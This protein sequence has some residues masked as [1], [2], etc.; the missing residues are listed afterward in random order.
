L[1]VNRQ[2]PDILSSTINFEIKPV[3]NNRSIIILKVVY[4]ITDTSTSIIFKNIIQCKNNDY[5]KVFIKLT[6]MKSD[7]N[8]TDYK[9]LCCTDN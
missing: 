5:I 6:N 4:I 1:D 8:A 7:V 2:P 9:I 3:L